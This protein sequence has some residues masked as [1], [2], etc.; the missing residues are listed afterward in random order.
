[1]ARGGAP[2]ADLLAPIDACLAARERARV[3]QLEADY[4]AAITPPAD[5]VRAATLLNAYNDDDIR[6]KVDALTPDQRRQMEAGARQATAIGSGD[7]VLGAL[8]T[9]TGTRQGQIFG[10]VA[11]T[12][13]PQSATT[14]GGAYGFVFTLTF[15]HDASVVNATQIAFVQTSRVVTTGTNTNREYM[16]PQNSRR[17]S[18]QEAI[19]RQAGNAFGWYGFGNNG[20]PNPHLANIRTGSAPTPLTPAW[21]YDRPSDNMTNVSFEFETSV[22]CRQGAQANLVYSVVHWGFTVDN[23]GAV[24]AIPVRVE[25]R[26]TAGFGEAVTAWNTQAAGP[27]AGRNAPSQQAL[28]AFR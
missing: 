1:M 14:P 15:T 28:P 24:T 25:D 12:G 7:R 23:A 6:R 4:A 2:V 21:L 16:E 19:D 27:S 3:A 22:I 18:R 20:Q 11:T 26:P 10:T 9:Q 13:T 17:N 5:W 8:R